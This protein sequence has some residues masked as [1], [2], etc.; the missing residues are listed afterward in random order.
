[1]KKPYLLYGTGLVLSLLGYILRKYQISAVKSIDTLLFTPMAWETLLLMAVILVSHIIIGLLVLGDAR[2]FPNYEYT[3]YSP[4]LPFLGINLLAGFLLL[5]S[6]FIGIM[7]IKSGYDI[8]LATASEEITFSF[9][10]LQLLE[11]SF[12]AVTGFLLVWLGKNAFEG[13]L[14]TERWVTVIPVFAAMMHLYSTFLRVSVTPGLQE[15]LYPILGG[16]SL[17]YGLHALA[18]SAIKEPC[19]RKLSFFAW[20][21]LLFYFVNL[22]T[23][24]S[25]YSALI[26][27]GLHLYLLSFGAAAIKNTYCS[28]MECSTPPMR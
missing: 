3:V 6:F 20:S 13:Q 25:V 17:I 15:K 8:F 10:V 14:L 1:M 11:L 9:P 2:S 18:T 28:Q 24:A 21:S 4:Y 19:P 5:L 27:T 16:L 26:T 7:D 12:M 23:L 22:S